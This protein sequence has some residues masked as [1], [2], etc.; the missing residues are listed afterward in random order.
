MQA[1]WSSTGPVVTFEPNAAL[2]QRLA[3]MSTGKA[4]KRRRNGQVFR[5]L[6]GAAPK[7][8]ALPA[9]PRTGATA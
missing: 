6:A 9:I 5:I 8:R 3:R 1:C 2:R 4:Q 7:I